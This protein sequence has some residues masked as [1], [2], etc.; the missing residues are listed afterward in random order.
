M[1]VPRMRSMVG[2]DT[3]TTPAGRDALDSP[4]MWQY[5]L[6][7][8]ATDVIVAAYPPGPDSCPSCHGSRL[9]PTG[10]EHYGAHEYGACPDCYGPASAAAW[11][12]VRAGWRPDSTP[13][14]T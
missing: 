3:D 14:P 4:P 11:A 9:M 1:T 10:V 6:T 12:L 5:H 8:Q 2:M 7:Q 13:D